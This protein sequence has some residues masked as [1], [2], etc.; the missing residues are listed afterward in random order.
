METFILKITNN[1]WIAKPYK[2][3][4]SALTVHGQPFFSTH[5]LLDTGFLTSLSAPLLI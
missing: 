5:S 1:L 3:L 2:L 4:A